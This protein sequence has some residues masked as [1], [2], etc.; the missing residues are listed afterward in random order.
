[1][2]TEYYFII[3]HIHVVCEEGTQKLTGEGRKL[4][5]DQLYYLYYLPNY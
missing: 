2:V 4:H 3:V 5:S 1:M